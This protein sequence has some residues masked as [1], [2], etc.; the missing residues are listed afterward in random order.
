MERAGVGHLFTGHAG[1]VGI[2]RIISWFQTA[3]ARS[4]LS[5]ILRGPHAV[6]GQDSHPAGPCTPPFW[7]PPASPFA[8][9]RSPT[10]RG[11]GMGDRRLDLPRRTGMASSSHRFH[12]PGDHQSSDRSHCKPSKKGHDRGSFPA[13]VPAAHGI[14]RHA[15]NAHVDD[16]LARNTLYIG[17]ISDHRRW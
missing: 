2:A 1:A 8:Q 9:S 6:R 7:L 15:G 16:Y 17:Y 13:V 4:Q 12:A 14:G 3:S 5:P 11:E 10:A